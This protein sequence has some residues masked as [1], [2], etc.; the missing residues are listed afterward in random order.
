MGSVDHGL[1]SRLFDLGGLGLRLH[2]RIPATMRRR[3]GPSAR[4]AA[5]WMTV[6]RID[7]AAT[8]LGGLDV[9]VIAHE[10]EVV[11]GGW[12]AGARRRVIEAP[13]GRRRAVEA[14]AA[15]ADR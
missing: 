4:I 12:P 8:A 9:V 10:E 14:V 15:G 6:G 1:C 5:R 11:Q 7:G 2:G 3:V 13:G